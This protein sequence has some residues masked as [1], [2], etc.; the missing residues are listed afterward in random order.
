MDAYMG[1]KMVKLIR[2][3]MLQH[4]EREKELFGR[5][6]EI[7]STIL[8]IKNTQYKFAV[9]AIYL[10]DVLICAVGSEIYDIVHSVEKRLLIQCTLQIII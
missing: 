2:D 7:I 4:G 1:T 3:F 10:C 6:E 5:S 9:S 8:H